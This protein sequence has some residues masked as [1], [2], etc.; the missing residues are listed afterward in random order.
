M[1]KPLF[2]VFPTDKRIAGIHSIPI[3]EDGSIIMVWDKNEKNLT[4][5]GGRIEGNEALRKLLIKWA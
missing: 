5:V 2:G 4:T 3:T 1:L